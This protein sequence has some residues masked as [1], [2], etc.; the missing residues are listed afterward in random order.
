[1]KSF[2][3]VLKKRI[4]K[5]TNFS[6]DKSTVQKTAQVCL[7]SLFGQL[8]IT[9]VQVVSFSDNKLFLSAKQSVW[10]AELVSKRKQIIDLINGKLG[11]KVVKYLQVRSW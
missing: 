4:Q 2:G 8:G 7:S 10:R 6:D 9:R 3:A 1:M 5:P 11:A